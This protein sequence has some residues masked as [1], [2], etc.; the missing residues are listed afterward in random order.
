ML[1]RAFCVVSVLPVNMALLHV[2]SS[3][4]DHDVD[5]VTDFLPACSKHFLAQLLA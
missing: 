3:V 1:Q 4:Q 2:A 5:T